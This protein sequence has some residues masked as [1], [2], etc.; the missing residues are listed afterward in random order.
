M[1]KPVDGILD[2][3]L[4]LSEDP[5]DVA[6]DSPTPV[7]QF[8][9]K[10]DAKPL[11]QE[12]TLLVQNNKVPLSLPVSVPALTVLIVTLTELVPVL[13]PDTTVFE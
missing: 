11:F 12:V 10:I 13:E 1:V 3:L 7:D 4:L 2:L 6:I 8:P 5:T 9:E